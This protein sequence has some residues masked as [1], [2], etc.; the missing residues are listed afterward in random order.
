[1]GLAGIAIHYNQPQ[2]GFIPGII[3]GIK[4]LGSGYLFRT[5]EV[6]KE[7]NRRSFMRIA[8]MS[9]GAGALFSGFAVETEC[10]K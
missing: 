2:C 6:M 5:E 7:I 9:L 1:M 3:W 10:R 4:S 8:G